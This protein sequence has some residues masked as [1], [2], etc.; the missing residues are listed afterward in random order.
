M[1]LAFNARVVMHGPDAADR[2][3]QIDL[4]FQM[5]KNQDLLQA[6]QCVRALIEAADYEEFV[7]T[8]VRVFC[9][10]MNAKIC[11]YNE[12]DPVRKR[13]TFVIHPREIISD[14]RIK[15][16]VDHAQENPL[17]QN[18]MKN[19]DDFAVYKITDFIE[20]REFRKTTLCRKLYAEM[21]AEYQIA[22]RLPLPDS[23][24]VA[25]VFNRAHDFTERDRELLTLLQPVIAAAYCNVQRM[26]NLQLSQQEYKSAVRAS[27][28]ARQALVERLSLS[29]RQNEVFRL[30]LQG[31]SNKQI[32]AKLKLSVRTIEKYVEHLLKKLNVPTR[33]A[34][35]A[36]FQTLLRESA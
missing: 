24:A 21:G 2:I 20:Q 35:C 3:S 23:P 29:H 13:F 19:P 10:L 31:K 5:L 16:W 14:A 7:A 22:L 36:R 30:L 26:S 8:L 9:P 32:A 18:A 27:N 17:V 34:A 12:A 11:G 33:A 25:V 4:Q 1:D 28:E 6:M 15:I